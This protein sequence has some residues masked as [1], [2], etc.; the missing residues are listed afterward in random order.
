MRPGARNLVKNACEWKWS[1]FHKYKAKGYYPEG[2][3]ENDA[4]V[5][6][7]EGEFGE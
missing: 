2:W 5:L 1:G 4:K 6:S 3:G 7:T